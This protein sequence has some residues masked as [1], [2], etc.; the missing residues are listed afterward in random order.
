MDTKIT[1]ELLTKYSIF[2]PKVHI[3]MIASGD[4]FITNSSAHSD[5][6]FTRNDNKTLAVEMEGAA[7]AQV[8]DDY[9]IPYVII[10]TISDKA[11]PSF[12]KD[13]DNWIRLNY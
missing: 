11:D 3:G 1:G 5:L 10:R 6:K 8:C 9:K 13:W 2:T 7:V 12:K 4:K